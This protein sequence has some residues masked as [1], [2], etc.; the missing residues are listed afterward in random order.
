MTS[1]W[2]GGAKTPPYS[3]HQEKVVLGGII[4]E[5]ESFKK[6][7]PI[8]KAGDAFFR[9][10]HGQIYDAAL[11][12]VKSRRKF[13]REQLVEKLSE[14]GELEK[15]GGERYI[16]ELAAGALSTRMVVDAARQVQDKA[17]LRK[18]ID[19]VSE[20]LNDAYGSGDGYLDVLARA[21]A[22]LDEVDGGAGGTA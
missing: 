15:I 14:R 7:R 22:R 6:V 5:P 2:V 19:A 11:A 1:A 18:L 20:V 9:S 21:R 17:M 13:G 8:I 16:D 3:V 4:A 10:Q 12:I